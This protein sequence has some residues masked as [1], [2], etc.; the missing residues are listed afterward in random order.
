MGNKSSSLN[1]WEIIKKK[2]RN[3]LIS[4][5]A[6]GTVGV[7]DLLFLNSF[8]HWANDALLI[9]GAIGLFIV[10]ALRAKEDE[11]HND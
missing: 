3:R 10:L 6:I 1:W 7:V 9:F 4:V 2:Y 8:L 11:E 5:I